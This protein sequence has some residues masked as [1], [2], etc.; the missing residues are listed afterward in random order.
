MRYAALAIDYDGTLATSGRVA[1]ETVR[2]LERVVESGRKV[3]LVTGRELDELIAVFPEIMI[4]DR[5]VAEN[6]AVLYTPST[7]ER[8]TLGDPPLPEFVRELARRGVQPLSIG[9]SIVATVQPHETVV[10]EAIRDLGLELNVV[11]NK[12]A[13]MILPASMNKASGLA[14]A[15]LDLG[16]SPRNVAA[17]GDAENDHAMLRFAE[18]GV[19]VGNALPALK[20]EADRVSTCENGEAVRELAEDLLRDDLQATPPRRRE[21]MLGRRFDGNELRIPA[22]CNVLIAGREQPGTPLATG[23]LKRV[24]ESGYQFCTIGTAD[25]YAT[26]L[27]EATVIGTGGRPAIADTISALQKPDASV[28]VD[29]GGVQGESRPAMVKDLHHALKRMRSST[30]RPHWI[31]MEGVER[32]LETESFPETIADEYGGM[33]YLATDVEWIESHV[34]ESVDVAVALDASTHRALT[35][36][37]GMRDSEL[38]DDRG[39]AVNAGDA[40][41]W[42][43]DDPRQSIWMHILP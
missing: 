21:I 28:I 26:A 8:R 37:A 14:V 17:I 12:G 13:V 36:V 19:A 43:R 32:M 9:R 22:S 35:N 40:V 2:A 7:S 41:V 6:G 30:G 29:I 34:M 20:V 4:F 16:L 5:V 31:L 3:I 38:P 25:E 27:P 42:R 18:F 1:D 15:L 24:Q 39:A 23:L 33:I 10:L 11:F